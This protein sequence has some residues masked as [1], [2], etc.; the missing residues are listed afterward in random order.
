[1]LTSLLSDEAARRAAAEAGRAYVEAHASRE[2]MLAR[3]DQVL[4]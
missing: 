3:W 1:V 2:L 4:V